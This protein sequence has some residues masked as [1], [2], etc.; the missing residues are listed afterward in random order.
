MA[1][2]SPE[3]L[4]ASNFGASINLQ[5]QHVF[6]DPEFTDSGALSFDTSKVYIALSGSPRQKA[7]STIV[8]P[9]EKPSSALRSSPHSPRA[10]QFKPS[11]PQAE[12]FRTMPAKEDGFSS[13]ER[14]APVS[15]L[16]NLNSSRPTTSNPRLQLLRSTYRLI[17][18]GNFIKMGATKSQSKSRNQLDGN[19]RVDSPV[20][21]GFWSGASAPPTMSPQSRPQTQAK[22]QS[23]GRTVYGGFYDDAS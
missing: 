7:H 12:P 21:W 8:K 23:R 14:V 17:P 3:R 1:S 4:Q 19:S 13:A 22:P 16:P 18:P 20:N 10:V 6:P 15:D 2:R 5:K 9:A 11:V